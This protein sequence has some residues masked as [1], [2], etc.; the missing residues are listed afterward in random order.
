MAISRPLELAGRSVDVWPVRLEASDTVVARFERVLEPGET[1]RAARF[2]F[3]HLQR[4]FILS[5]GALRVLL[6]RYL[7]ISPGGVQFRYGPKGKPSL[8]S[9]G[10]L[11]FN[12]SHSGALALFAFTLERE[13]GVDVEHIRALP[14]MQQ[15]ASRFFCAEE[16]EE[17]SL[18]PTDQRE[19]AFFSCWTR[20]E[21]YVKAVGEGLSAPLD[22][23]RVTLRP[24][25]PARFIHVA[26]DTAA[27]DAW[28]LH[29]VEPASHYVAA[30]AYQ[31]G[32]RPV[33]VRPPIEPA[34]LLDGVM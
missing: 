6:G 27:A 19:R 13:I 32:L 16:A 26:H 2:R 15:I 10:P 21:A 1:A 3:D 33:H 30:L 7:E 18:I 23:F 34:E 31:D 12:A 20:K 28:M 25:E 4:S 14:D 8:A 9:P 5:R 29:N 22:S 24:G 11:Q 17:L